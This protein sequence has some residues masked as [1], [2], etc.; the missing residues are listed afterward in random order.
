MLADDGL[1]AALR[2]QFRSSR[3]LAFGCLL[4]FDSF[5]FKL[6]DKHCSCRT[7]AFHCLLCLGVLG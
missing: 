2:G 7:L 4:R 5:G 1:W 3:R 6:P